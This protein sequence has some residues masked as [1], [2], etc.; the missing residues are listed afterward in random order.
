MRI[1]YATDK[2][3]E[4]CQDCPFSRNITYVPHCCIGPYGNTME[5]DN[6]PK[7]YNIVV[8]DWC[9]AKVQEE[10]E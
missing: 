4:G 1:K 7:R 6:Y 2:E 5:H 3:I 9:P 10:G 8:P